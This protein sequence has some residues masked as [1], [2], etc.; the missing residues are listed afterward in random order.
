MKK[1]LLLII[2]ALALSM[3]LAIFGCGREETKQQE[4][5]HDSSVVAE[6]ISDGKFTLN[7]TPEATLNPYST[8]S[9]LNRVVDQLVY[10]RIDRFPERLQKYVDR[11]DELG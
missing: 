8:T 6:V 10:E 1:S 9:E 7:Y 3:S 5:T 2:A 4:E 11:L